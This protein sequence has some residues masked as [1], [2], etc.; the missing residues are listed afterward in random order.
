MMMKNKS[1][2]VRLTIDY[3]VSVP[4]EWDENMIEF[5]RNESSFC[6][7]TD[8]RD[9]ATLIELTDIC[10]CSS[11]SVKYLRDTEQD[12]C[13]RLPNISQGWNDES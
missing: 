11:S 12:D 5:H 10:G 8:I 7:G 2:V 4:E 3:V 13:T 6:V 1:I 9:L